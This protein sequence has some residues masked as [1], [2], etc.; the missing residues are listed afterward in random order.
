MCNTQCI[1]DS[2]KSPV[3][4]NHN[5]P[6]FSGRFTKRKASN[7]FIG[8]IC[9]LQDKNRT[10]T[11]NLKYSGYVNNFSIILQKVRGVRVPRI[12]WSLP[13][14]T[15]N[16]RHLMGLTVCFI[17]Y[18]LSICYWCIFILF[19]NLPWSY[20]TYSLRLGNSIYKLFHYPN[21]ERY[22]TGINKL[23]ISQARRKQ[24]KSAER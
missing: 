5:I 7:S 19:I 11:T 3:I 14:V 6:Y 13:Y 15:P 4:L 1:N 8:W 18:K 23:L 2:F 16:V 24:K 9:Y 20:N 17:K 22:K 12:C 21:T 10:K